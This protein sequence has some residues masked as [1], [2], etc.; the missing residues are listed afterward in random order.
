[1]LANVCRIECPILVVHGENDETIHVE[2]A[3]SIADAAANARVA[4]IKN[5][6]HV[7]NAPNPPPADAREIPELAQAIDE[8]VEFSRDCCDTP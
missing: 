8:I 1:M 7:F 2:S 4:R 3:M 6:N 5:C